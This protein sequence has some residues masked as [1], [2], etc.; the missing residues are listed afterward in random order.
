MTYTVYI[1]IQYTRGQE[2][3]AS[4]ICIGR[5]LKWRHEAGG[6]GLRH[7]GATG[8]RPRGGVPLSDLW[9]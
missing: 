3:V 1:Y 8:A 4:A 2:I 9:R 6:V 7:G 5:L